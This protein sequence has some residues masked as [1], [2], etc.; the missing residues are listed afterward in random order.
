M[1][2][3][4]AKFTFDREQSFDFFT[5]VAKR[6][7]ERAQG[8]TVGWDE[9]CFFAQIIWFIDSWVRWL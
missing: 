8:I 9:I 4:H 2:E 1:F 3:C 5:F 6:E 7:R